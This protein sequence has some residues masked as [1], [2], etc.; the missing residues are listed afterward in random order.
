M[1]EK[2][3]N[4]ISLIYRFR[5]LNRDQIQHMLNHSDDAR[6][7]KW[8][9]ELIEQGYCGREYTKHDGVNR[10]PAIYYLLR[11][12]VLTIQQDNSYIAKL[13]NESAVSMKTKEHSLKAAQFYLL[14]QEYADEHSHILTYRTKADIANTPMYGII[15]PDAYFSYQTAKGK[16]EVCVEI[17]METES[18]G[19]IQAKLNTYFDYYYQGKKDIFPSIALVCITD[20]RQQQLVKQTEEILETYHFIPVTFK[21]T[22]CKSIEQQ[23][24]LGKIWHIPYQQELYWLV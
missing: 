3:Q 10:S 22:T 23:G 2:Q 9:T 24:I 21:I 11:K 4:I 13:R 19:R 16:K 7:N 15:K 6:V 14:L 17:D 1:T 5:F 8:L 12:G 20:T 18:K